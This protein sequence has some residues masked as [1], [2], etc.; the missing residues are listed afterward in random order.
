MRPFTALWIDALRSLLFE[1]GVRLITFSGPRF[2]SGQPEKA[3]AR[4]VSQNPQTSWILAHSNE[5]IQK[6]FSEQSVPCVLAGSNHPSYNLPNVDLDYFGVCRHA[7]GAMLRNGHRRIT[8]LTQKSQR[9]GDLESEAGFTAGARQPHYE[10]VNSTI[11]RHDGT[12]RGVNR[13]LTRL[14]NYGSPPT[15][16]LVANPS[17][18]LTTITFLAQR[19]LRVPD[20]I[21]LVCR[22]D[23]S[24][25][26]FLN[27]SP[28]RYSCSPLAYAKRI[29]QPVLVKIR[30]E[31]LVK[32]AIR[33][34]VRYN[35]GK[36][37]KALA[38]SEQL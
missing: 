11:V 22:D 29:L 21:S 8:F 32:S 27:P 16:I 26:E 3:L 14:F 28:T 20:D 31:P 24:F 1:N 37:L 30:G 13:M 15:A 17:Y 19:G 9:A 18:Y 4:L 35:Q 5:P 7:V 36:S 38:G 6:W 12:P 25:L 33:I 23:D 34:E 10:N 2:F